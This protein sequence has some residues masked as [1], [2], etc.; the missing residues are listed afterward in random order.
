MT[1]IKVAFVD[2]NNIPTKWKIY[3]GRIFDL[4]KVW[5]DLSP[6]YVRSKKR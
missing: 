2:P 4:D 5:R 1:S 6:I 3:Q